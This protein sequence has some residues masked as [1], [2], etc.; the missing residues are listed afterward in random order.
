M[1]QW[2]KYWN[3]M[4]KKFWLPA[5]QLQSNFTFHSSKVY[6]SL[7]LSLSLCLA[8]LFLTLFI[9]SPSPSPSPSLFQVVHDNID[10]YF[11]GFDGAQYLPRPWLKAVYP[12]D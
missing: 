9:L 12:H 8:K 10:D 3:L 4:H 1:N 11:V 2:E 7:S 6:K 5:S